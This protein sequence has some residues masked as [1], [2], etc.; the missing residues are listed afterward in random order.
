MRT[1]KINGLIQHK[2]FQNYCLCLTGIIIIVLLSISG[3]AQDVEKNVPT[4][5][6][7]FVFVEG[8][9][10]E[11]GDIWDDGYS[12]DEHPVHTVVIQSFWMSTHEISNAQYCLFLN[13][14]GNPVE[15]G[16]N[17]L[18]REDVDCL[19]VKKDQQY[20]SKEGFETHP[21][22]EVTWYGAQAFAEWAGGRL[23]TEA[24][25]EFAAR[26]GGRSTKFP[27]GQNLS[28]MDAN[29]MGIGDR[30]RWMRTSPVGSFLPNSI[31]L[32]DMAGNVWEWC[33]DWYE[34]GYY[35][36][37]P[38]ENPDGPASGRFNILRGGSWEYTWWNCRTTT[39]GRNAPDDAAG[40]V[41]FRIVRV[42][43][44]FNP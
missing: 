18:D 17:W 21:V 35:Q 24:E 29:F 28:H 1:F 30:D 11:M 15:G 2:V 37:S 44:D 8:S 43:D 38:S 7:E 42:A 3:Y 16:T 9:S 27:N 5:T 20:V 25:W 4:A 41:G 23:P 10:F 40:D 22:V 12:D 31:G 26:N 33:S 39:R 19:I 6:I 13:E 32:F 34:A 36:Q 14:V